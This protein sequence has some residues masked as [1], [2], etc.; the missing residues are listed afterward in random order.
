MVKF[1]ALGGLKEPDRDVK[2]INKV[3]TGNG[4]L[5]GI[6]HQYKARFEG[7]GKARRNGKDIEVHLPLKENVQPIAQKLRRVP[8]NLMDSLKKR[9]SEFVKSE[10][11][12]KV[13]EHDSITWC[14]P[15]VV[16]PK[17]KNASDI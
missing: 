6:I 11:M 1:D 16:Q 14:S 3:E 10:I 12:E 15:L 7:I 8:Y 17:A 2:V 9:I 5:D 13:P 4:E